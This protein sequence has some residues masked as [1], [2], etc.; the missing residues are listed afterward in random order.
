MT[1]DTDTP[2]AASVEAE[3]DR[4]ESEVQKFKRSEGSPEWFQ[5]FR[6]QHGI[7]GQRQENVQM[8]RVK[9]PAGTVNADQLD[10]LA[11]LADEYS[12]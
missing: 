5:R 2:I 10:C 7:Y 6:L 1:K 11:D 12:R 3:I 9:I 4:Y 8:V